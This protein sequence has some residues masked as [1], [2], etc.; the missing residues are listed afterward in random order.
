MDATQGCLSIS[1]RVLDP[2]L[3]LQANNEFFGRQDTSVDAAIFNLLVNPDRSPAGY[4]FSFTNAGLVAPEDRHAEF[5]ATQKVD[6]SIFNHELLMRVAKEFKEYAWGDDD[7]PTLKDGIFEIL[8][9]SNS[10]PSF[11]DCGFEYIDFSFEE[12]PSSNPSESRNT[13]RTS[14]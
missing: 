10:S 7:V 6:V 5:L 13:K 11:V 3:V 9:G 12:N 4:G 14:P 1:I 2:A 8:V